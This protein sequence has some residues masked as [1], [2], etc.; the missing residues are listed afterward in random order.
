MLSANKSIA[1][2]DVAKI[3]AAAMKNAK[4]F[5]VSSMKDFNAILLGPTLSLMKQGGIDPKTYSW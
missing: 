3:K 2:Q 4:A 5:Q 1:P